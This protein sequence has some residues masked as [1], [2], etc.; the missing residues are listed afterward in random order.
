VVF[1]TAHSDFGSRAQSTLK[2]GNDFIAKP[3]L[4]V[5]LA[6]KAL[7]CLFKESPQAL[8]MA[9]AQASALGGTRSE[10]LQ[11]SAGH[12]ALSVQEELVFGP[13]TIP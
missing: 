12:A 3:F 10:E 4:L 2:G 13:N 9:T 8:S 11:P 1:V 7:T 5:E 6:V